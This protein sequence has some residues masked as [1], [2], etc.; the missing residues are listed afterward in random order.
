MKNVISRPKVYLRNKD[1]NCFVCFDIKVKGENKVQSYNI[2][3]DFKDIT[4]LKTCHETHLKAKDESR[5]LLTNNYIKQSDPAKPKCFIFTFKHLL[6]Y[7]NTFVETGM[8]IKDSILES[9]TIITKAQFPKYMQSHQYKDTFIPFGNKIT[10]I[11]TN[12]SH[13]GSIIMGNGIHAKVEI[14][15]EFNSKLI[16]VNLD[17]T[18]ELKDKYSIV[19]CE[20]DKVR[21]IS[22]EQTLEYVNADTQGIIYD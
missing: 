2:I 20:C 9:L 7:I 21:H 6:Y 5:S 15:G 16:C 19:L 1:G 4:E 22:S 3:T 12:Y 8:P 10:D 13:K 17:E 18:K 14:A 11:N